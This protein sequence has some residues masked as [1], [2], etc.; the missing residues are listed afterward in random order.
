[1]MDLEQALNAINSHYS[2]GYWYRCGTRDKALRA[3]QALGDFQDSRAVTALL[4]ILKQETDSS[5]LAAAIQSLKK[6]NDPAIPEK[7]INL[8]SDKNWQTRRVAVWCFEAAGRF[9]ALELLIEAL[10][11]K[12]PQ[13]CYAAAQALG[14]LPDPRGI[15]S[16]VAL[17]RS[18]PLWGPDII[19]QLRSQII[20]TLQTIQKEGD[21]SRNLMK[22]SVC[23]RCLCRISDHKVKLRWK[24]RTF[25]FFG[26]R[27]CHCLEPR[28]EGVQ[29]IKLVLDQRWRDEAVTFSNGVLQVNFLSNNLTT[30]LDELLI[31]AVGP[32]DIQA[33]WIAWAEKADAWQR[34]RLKSVPVTLLPGAQVDGMTMDLLKAKF[35]RVT[36]IE[37]TEPHLGGN[38][39]G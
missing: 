29:G 24:W 18:L 1:M 8:L 33:F 37:E 4:Q 14:R 28:F 21:K 2:L 34:K 32:W 7:V 30:D 3:A 26:C 9:Q 12:V 22:P 23:R 19:W 16:L 25:T 17:W 36:K 38:L 13:V 35:A 6:L 5:V 27:Q 20:E 11:D 15:T 10:K 31:G 39:R